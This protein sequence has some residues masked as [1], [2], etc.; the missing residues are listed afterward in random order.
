MHGEISKERE[1]KR[2]SGLKRRILKTCN[3]GRLDRYGNKLTRGSCDI[4]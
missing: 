3:L 4:D 1:R 2:S